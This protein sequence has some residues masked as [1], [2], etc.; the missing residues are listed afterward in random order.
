[1]SNRIPLAYADVELQLSTA[2]AIGGTSFSVSSANDDDGVALPAG[3][4]CFTLDNGSTNK[5]YLIGQ[6]NGTDVT[7]V[8][9]VSRQGV[10]TSGAVRAHRVG[11]GCIITDFATIQRVADILRGQVDLDG[12]SPIGYDAEPTL[13]D[14]KDLATVG[15]VLD[16]VTGGTVSFDNMTCAGNGGEA[17]VAGNLVYFKTSD[18][19][20]YLTDA[21]TAATI[22]GVQLGIALGTGSN[23]VA[24]TGGIQIAG[25]WTTTGL[26]AGAL[27][28]AGN[29]AGAISASA[30]TTS[31][32]IGLALSTT[33]LLIIPRN[34][35]TVSTNEKAAL[36]GNGGTPSSSNKF[37][38]QQG[39]SLT[40]VFLASGT[41]TKPAGASWMEVIAIGSGGGGGGGCAGGTATGGAGGGAGQYVSVRIE[42]S[43]AGATEAV[44]VGNGGAGG[45]GSA[46]STATAGTVGVNTTF[47]SLVT[48]AGG[49]AGLAPVTSAAPGVSVAKN[50]IMEAMYL[51]G[52]TTTA[53]MG[54]GTSGANVAGQAAVAGVSEIPTGGGQ[55]GGNNSL[56]PRAGGA[57]GSISGAITRE[58]GT[59]GNGSNGGAGTSVTANSPKGGTGGGGGGGKIESGNGY[60]GGA[61]GNYGGGGGGGG[62]SEVATGGAGGAG[63]AGICVVITHF[64]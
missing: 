61:G 17:I 12:S 16:I 51:L 32:V 53:G 45:A 34:P 31:Q 58:G 5:E 13:S 8:Y 54:G 10:E 24:I 30:G 48:A 56:T 22:E 47:G 64:Q 18:Q 59:A 60:A 50:A 2:I 11:T 1:M 3:K 4:Y 26:T 52:S 23:G 15:Y 42:A 6:L 44:T 39:L 19:E 37:V 25:T 55:G 62:S 14:R 46:T 38:T 28:Y 27:Y 43:Q 35:Q 33:K 21:D 9:N 20:W 41:W 29:T 36:A 49:T 40:E 7:A 57:G 63:G